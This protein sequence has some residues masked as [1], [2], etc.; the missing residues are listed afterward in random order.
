MNSR[1]NYFNFFLCI[2]GTCARAERAVDVRRTEGVA[3][4]GE[5]LVGVDCAGRYPCLA[6]GI[7][8]LPA[9][10]DCAGITYKYKYA[11]HRSISYVRNTKILK[12]RV[13]GPITQSILPI[14][15][16]SGFRPRLLKYINIRPEISNHT[17]HITKM[18]KS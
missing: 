3:L 10:D 15:P 9:Q 11:C 18:I 17:E 16:K 2:W 7:I 5:E 6:V 13:I 14:R 8:S 4:P 12:S 1:N